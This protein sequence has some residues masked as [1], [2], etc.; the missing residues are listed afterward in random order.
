VPLRK[1]ISASRAGTG[2]PFYGKLPGTQA[3]DKTIVNALD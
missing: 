3:L 1:T 2:P